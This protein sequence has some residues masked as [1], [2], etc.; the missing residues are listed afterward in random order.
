MTV[1]TACSEA[2][3]ELVGR[4]LSALFSTS[5]QF[6]LELRTQAN[7]T[8][9]AIQKAH[10]WRALT[11]LATITGDGT[12]EAF[13]LPSDYDRMPVKADLF[14]A[15]TTGRLVRAKD[16]DHWLDMKIR[17]QSAIVGAWILLGGQMNIFPAQTTGEV[18]NYYYQS[19]A[20]VS[21]ATGSNKENFT[22][23][24]DTF[25]L[26]EKLLTLGVIWRWRAMKRL[27]YAEDLKNFEIAMAEEVGRDKG[28]R[29]LTVGRTRLPGGTTPAYPY[30][31]GGGSIDGL[32]EDDVVE[33][34]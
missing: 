13:N 3:V 32:T 26:S 34:D 28:S 23:D 5:D 33:N 14:Y 25:R 20:V 1:L 6:A 27:E 29:I 19:N 9:R 17:N 7:R 10:D 24:T 22:L 11:T 12:S 4:E 30:A 2:A 8:A 31:I 15:D 16:L 18:I 21:P